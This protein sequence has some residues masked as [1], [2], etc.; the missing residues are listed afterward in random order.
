ML[1]ESDELVS[2][3]AVVAGTRLSAPGALC[4]FQQGYG[5]SIGAMASTLV[6]MTYNLVASDGLQPKS[7]GLYRNS[8]GRGLP[9]I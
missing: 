6:T 1:D 9:N 3:V 7:D 5:L 4:E 8:D 2:V